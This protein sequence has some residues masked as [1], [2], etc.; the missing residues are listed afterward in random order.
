MVELDKITLVKRENDISKSCKMIVITGGIIV[1]ILC[2]IYYNNTEIYRPRPCNMIE[3]MKSCITDD[4]TKP[5]LGKFIQFV[6]IDK[7]ILPINQIIIID[8]DY[9]MIPIS[10]GKGKVSHINEKGSILEFELPRPTYINQFIIDLN[11]ND[12]RCDNILTTQ[13][14]IRDSEYDTV[15][16]N[17][18]QLYVDR[19]VDVYVARPHMIY[20]IPQ[21]LLDPNLSKNDQEVT[22]G[23][24]LMSNTW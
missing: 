7:K 13:V 12:K 3:P 1:L 14:R 10:L 9:N 15:W 20:P 21:Q 24:H 8:K 17:K 19:Y 4:K 5:V 16:T 23:Y 11:I 2:F 22:L 6:N 18:D